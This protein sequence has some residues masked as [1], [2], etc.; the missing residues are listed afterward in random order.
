MKA[1]V[2]CYRILR[3]SEYH[4]IILASS[5]AVFESRNL[6][7]D[8]FGGRLRIIV[9]NATLER[10]GEYAHSLNKL[11]VFT[12]IEYDKVI[13]YDV[14]SHLLRLPVELFA[15]DMPGIEL[16][17]PLAY[18]EVDPCFHTSLMLVR[19]SMQ[20]YR[21]LVQYANTTRGYDMDVLNH[22]FQFKSPN[23]WYANGVLVLPYNYVCLTPYAGERRYKNF[24]F[25]FTFK[26]ELCSN[27]A[28]LHFSIGG[29]PWGY[30]DPT[31]V[32]GRT[33]LIYNLYNAV[34]S[35]VFALD[36]VQI[37]VLDV[38]FPT[39]LAPLAPLPPPLP[40]SSDIVKTKTVV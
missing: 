4:C 33:V 35:E 19:P 17:A 23:G 15:I 5:A 30:F 37:S 3:V 9:R 26:S 34:L 6:R 36:E 8:S 22:Y 40:S 16:A 2:H 1:F 10:L 25:Q 39:P 29:K 38:Q 31:I 7:F 11:E 14:D 21:Q 32:D 20:T 27:S 18:W 28:L 13:Y 12:L 24:R